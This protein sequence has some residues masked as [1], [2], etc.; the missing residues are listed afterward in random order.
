MPS[1]ET[2]PVP[3][4]TKARDG[5][6][7]I[8][9]VVLTSDADF[10]S[11][12]VWQVN[13]AGVSTGAWV[14][15]LDAPDTARRVLGLC[16]RRAVIAW[17]PAEPLSLLA[18]LTEVTGGQSRSWETTAIALPEVIGEIVA[19]RTAYDK[20]VAAERAAGRKVTPI[21]WPVAMP[22]LVPT[23]EDGFW[24]TTGL[25]L[26]RSSPVAEA[27]LRTCG[28]ARWLAQRWAETM[29]VLRRR[30][31]LRDEFGAPAHL[32]AVWETRLADAHS[33]G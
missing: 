32:P 3:A 5:R 13:T 31:Y 6:T 17:Q 29:V 1:E 18:E 25:A 7:M 8:S 12:A 27:A 28:I 20:R 22:T 30:E 23:S 14:L 21:T 10:K 2:T 19:T 15:P 9:A 4:P 26:P 33:A 11:V 24:R 16:L